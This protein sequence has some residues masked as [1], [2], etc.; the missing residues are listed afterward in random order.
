MQ[1]GALRLLTSRVPIAS[2]TSV[3]PS[4]AFPLMLGGLLQRLVIPRCIVV[5][6]VLKASHCQSFDEFVAERCAIV[7]HIS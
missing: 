2:S 7:C 5:H 1:A 6:D 4:I 3:V